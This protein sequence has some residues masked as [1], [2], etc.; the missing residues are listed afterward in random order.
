MFLAKPIFPSTIADTINGCL[1]AGTVCEAEPQDAEMPDLTGRHLLLAE[2]VE[3]NREIV[4]AMLEATGITLDTAENGAEEVRMFEE[5]PDRYDMIFMD[6]QM[7]EMDGYEA[8]RRIRALEAP[9]AGTIPIIATTANAFREDIE[10]CLAAGMSD[11]VP[12]PLNLN[13]V[14][15]VLRKY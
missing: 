13:N 4:S 15:S 2:D 9:N 10:K 5:D 6:V 1:S 12:K 11:H 14:L 7:P 3:V 8:T